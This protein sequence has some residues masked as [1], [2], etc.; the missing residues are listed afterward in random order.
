MPVWIY[1]CLYMKVP[2]EARRGYQSLWKRHYPCLR[3]AGCGCW[4]ANSGS[5][6]EGQVL[7]TAEASLQPHCASHFLQGIRVFT[8]LGTTYSTGVT[9]GKILQLRYFYRVVSGGL[10][11]SCQLYFLNVNTLD[12]RVLDS[13]QSAVLLRHNQTFSSSSLL[14]KAYHMTPWEQHLD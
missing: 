13:R 11:A 7:W 14:W 1:V 8:I 10:G 5:L 2:A 3:A 4:E 6:E 9:P 12:F